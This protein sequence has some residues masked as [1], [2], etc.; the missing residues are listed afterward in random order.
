VY[1]VSDLAGWLGVLVI[2]ESFSVGFV[3]VI[4]A[5]LLLGGVAPPPHLLC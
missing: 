2:S 5:V 3:S 1:S 4:A